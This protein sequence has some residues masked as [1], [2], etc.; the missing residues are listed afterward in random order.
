VAALTD[1]VRVAVRDPTRP[2]RLLIAC[3]ALGR[4][5]RGYEVFA[6]ELAEA[7]QD[8]AD[9]NVRLAQSGPVERPW[10]TRV[11]SLPAG[12]WGNRR[13]SGL[14]GRPAGW[15]EYVT[16]T[17]GLVPTLVR[18]R[19][20]VVLCSERML[21]TALLRLRD[22]S[23]LGF[24]VLFSNGGP[25]MPPFDGIDLVHQVTEVGLEEA[26]AAGEAPSRHVVI[27]YGF[28][29]E[30]I[31]TCDRK[32]LRR[33]LG[34]PAEGPVVL[35]IGALDARRKRMHHLIEEVAALQPQPYL[36]ML[37]QETVGTPAMRALAA[38]RFGDRCLITT[39]APRE[40][41]RWVAAA[42]VF[43][44]A[45][46][47]EGFGRAYIDAAAGGLPCVVHDGPVM[48]AV[49]GDLGTYADMER[50]GALQKAVE[51]VLADVE[52]MTP[53]ARAA[54]ADAVRA[55]F[56]WDVLA[57]RYADAV[58]ELARRRRP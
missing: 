24:A 56:S 37:G 47:V 41:I 12:G 21:A 51:D 53:T 44:L 4:V 39:V 5:R 40:I 14:A 19:P 18:W 33:S 2:T 16:F 46:V 54:R 22:V 23:R 20:D 49:L 1:R 9:L 29:F 7:L 42:D 28:R 38:E 34:L 6:D 43:A 11:P 13:M 27:P 50:P 52:A 48:R 32:A 31:P 25:S 55:R 36:V 57:P 15:S 35:S 17:A 58:L 30:A 3:P 10:A 45:S 8:R 26:L